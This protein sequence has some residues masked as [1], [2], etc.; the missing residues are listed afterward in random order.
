MGRVESKDQKSGMIHEMTIRAEA[1]IEMIEAFIW[2][3]TKGEGLGDEFLRAVEATLAA[4]KR[5][6]MGYPSA[7]KK[8]RRALLR[9]FPYGIFY[10]V[11]NFQIVVIACFHSSRDPRQWQGRA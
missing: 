7:F 1:Q 5:N 10:F 8:I 2:Y 6:P 9:R 11:E 3:E 4:L